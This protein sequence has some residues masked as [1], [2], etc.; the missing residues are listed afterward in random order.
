VV[1]NAIPE[2]PPWLSARLLGISNLILESHQRL[3][4]KA[5]L[6]AQGSRL[7]AQELFVLDRVVLCHDGSE[8]PQFIYA[9]RAA[10]LLFRRN[11]EGMVG[12]PS[13]LSAS[14]QQRL[15]RGQLLEQAR[16]QKALVDYGGERVDAQGRRFQIRGARLWNLVDEE[17]HYR[18]QAACFSDWWWEP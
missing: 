11:W 1:P 14:P 7:A 13:R 15:K 2:D 5:L 16:R 10:L 17:R 9:N 6:Q 18:G 8:D 3:F 12:M 4:G